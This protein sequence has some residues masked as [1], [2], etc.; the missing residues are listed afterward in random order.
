MT[1]AEPCLS[2][3]F[4]GASYIVCSFDLAKDDLRILWRGPDALPP[5]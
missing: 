4:R 5:R 1:Q 2:E 3:S